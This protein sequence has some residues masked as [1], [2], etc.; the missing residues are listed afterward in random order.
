MFAAVDALV[1]RALRDL[2]VREALR[3]GR[4]DLAA[5]AERQCAEDLERLNRRHPESMSR[6][7]EGTQT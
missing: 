5:A 2:T 6:N 1:C 7:E 4:H 3:A